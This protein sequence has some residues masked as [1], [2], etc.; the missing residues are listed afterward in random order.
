MMLWFSEALR[1]HFNE[2]Q[3][4]IDYKGSLSSG[5]YN[6]YTNIVNILLWTAEKKLVQQMGEHHELENNQTSR[7]YKIHIGV[8]SINDFV[9]TIDP[10]WKLSDDLT[11][12]LMKLER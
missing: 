11:I 2:F 10:K 7:D 8:Y 3:I 5:S 4:S 9:S 1:C 12:W 6:G